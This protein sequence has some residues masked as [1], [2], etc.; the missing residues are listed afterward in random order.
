[1]HPNHPSSIHRPKAGS[2]A[3]GHRA[4][5]ICDLIPFPSSQFPYPCISVVPFSL[6]LSF[7]ACQS[8]LLFSSVSPQQLIY[9]ERRI[10]IR[11]EPLAT[12]SC[13]NFS[14]TSERKATVRYNQHTAQVQGNTQRLNHNT[15]EVCLNLEPLL[16]LH[17]FQPWRLPIFHCF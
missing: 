8:P 7:L 4:L 17:Q 16:F 10:R 2:V 12:N 14:E 9:W 1:M 13:K 15:S 5:G 11:D 6:V 3:Q